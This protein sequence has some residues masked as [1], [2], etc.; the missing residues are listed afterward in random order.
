MRYVG[1]CIRV[2]QVFI[3]HRRDENV[4]TIKE[5]AGE[6]VHIHTISKI[7]G[8]IPLRPYRQCTVGRKNTHV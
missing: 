7:V 4:D 6:H 5:T 2:R 8:L 1:M 3:V